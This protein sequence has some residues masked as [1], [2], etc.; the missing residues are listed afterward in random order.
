MMK[1]IEIE[2]YIFSHTYIYLP[3]ILFLFASQSELHRGSSTTVYAEY[4]QASFV[5]FLHP[6]A[7]VS[8]NDVEIG[9]GNTHCQCLLHKMYPIPY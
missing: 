2:W 8:L 6:S 7:R 1:Q 3:A 4:S 9:A 5:H